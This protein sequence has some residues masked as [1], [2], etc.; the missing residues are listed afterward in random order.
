M[1]F[2][3]GKVRGAKKGYL[4]M[5]GV[6]NKFINIL[7]WRWEMRCDWT[8]LQYIVI[9]VGVCENDYCLLEILIIYYNGMYT[10]CVHIYILRVHIYILRTV[11]VCVSPIVLFT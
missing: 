2:Y 3:G 7:S 9:A 10:N 5:E 4:F 8:S 1:H 6:S 11:H